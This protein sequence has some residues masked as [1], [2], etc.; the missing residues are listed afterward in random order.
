MRRWQDPFPPTPKEFHDRVEQTLRGL[1]DM[2]MKLTR[3]Y[4]KLT[5][6]LIAALIALLAI[7]AVAAVIGNNQLKDELS[8]AGAKDMAERVQDVHLADAGDGFNF[9]VDE[10]A[11]EGDDLYISYT[12]SV[13]EDGNTY[14]VGLLAPRINGRPANYRVGGYLEDGWTCSTIALGGKYPATDTFVRPIIADSRELDLK[15]M[16][17]EV[18]AAFFK[19][20]RPLQYLPDFYN[21]EGDYAHPEM[22]VPWESARRKTTAFPNSNTLYYW[23]LDECGAPMVDL[24]MFPDVLEVMSAEDAVEMGYAFDGRDY[25]FV[26]RVLTPKGLDHTGIAKL[27]AERSISLPLSK[28]MVSHDLYNGLEENTF[29]YDDMTITVENFRMTHFKI[30]ARIWMLPDEGMPE[31]DDEVDFSRFPGVFIEVN[32]KELYSSMWGGTEFMRN[33]TS[34]FCWDYSYDGYVPLGELQSVRLV[35]KHWDEAKREYTDEAV[36]ADLTPIL[37]TAAAEEEAAALA[38]REAAGSWQPG[39]PEIT[40]WATEGGTYYHLEEHCSGMYSA[41][42]WDISK[43]V[44]DGKKPCP[45]C[46]GGE[47][48]PVELEEG[49]DISCFQDG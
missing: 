7:G 17:L 43:A 33:D 9:A 16:K 21:E 41:V 5:T 3:R 32:G 26:D 22:L 46:A 29:R 23:N 20:N 34:A 1:E 2:D 19:A 45:V 6:L 49:E 15:D 36:I 13:P 48:G 25:A 14:L 35:A 12:L 47:P 11:W 31:K 28:D 40:V 18:G 4:K 44:E 39:D 42:Q 10:V 8:D 24:W 37:D 38:T 27:A 30:E